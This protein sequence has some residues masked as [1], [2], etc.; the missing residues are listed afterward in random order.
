FS[1]RVAALAGLSGIGPVTVGLLTQVLGDPD[2]DVRARAAWWLGRHGPRAG[3]GVDAL[4]EALGDEDSSVGVVAAEAL[5][6]ICR[7]PAALPALI[8]GLEDPVSMAR[9]RAAEALGRMGAD[10][11]AAVP[12]L[13][14][15]L[16]EE[17]GHGAADALR[18]LGSAA[19]AAVP[20][21][22]GMLTEEVASV[23]WNAARGLGGLGPAGPPAG[24]A[25]V[26]SLRGPS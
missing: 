4:V 6:R 10:A 22:I 12:A 26:G 7:H 3:A 19:G 11:E 13:V 5:W 24:G 23:R 18:Q 21:L 9:S 14:E 16:R 17:E 20:A 1:D 15:A 2:R 8:A 25:P